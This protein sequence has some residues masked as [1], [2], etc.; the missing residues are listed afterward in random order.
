MVDLRE[1]SVLSDQSLRRLEPLLER[2]RQFAERSA[3]AG[4]LAVVTP[5]VVERFVHARTTRG[6]TAPSPA[7]MHA[8][9]SAVRL[10]FRTGRRL[11]LCVSD[12]TLDVVLPPR[13][14]LRA[15]PLTDDEVALCRSASLYSLD[16]TRL[17]AA[18]ALAEATVRSGELA[19]VRVTHVDLDNARVW[20]A[21]SSR[22]EPRWGVLSTWGCKQL[23]R[24]LETLGD[25]SL[26]VYA[27]AGSAESRQ[28]SSCQAIHETLVRAGLTGEADVRPVSVAAWAGRAAFERT[29]RVEDAARV[30]GVRTLDRAA[31]VI[32]WDWS[33]GEA[34]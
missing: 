18:W 29:G 32:G 28:A 24:R 19:G 3:G 15:R 8:R 33:T 9:R 30:L 1:T 4:A 26:V 31:A 25:A 16:A 27:G 2:F 23:G 21:G 7:T 5:D 6:R 17:P 12:P 13:S 11:G 22:T 20:I 10:L 14:G 34:K